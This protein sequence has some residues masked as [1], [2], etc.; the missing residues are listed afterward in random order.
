[1]DAIA[2]IAESR[3][4]EAQEK[5]AFDNLPGMGKPLDLS[6]EANVPQE[7]KMAYTLLKNAGYI[8]GAAHH[9]A[10][11]KKSLPQ[12]EAKA[13]GLLLQHELAATLK[14]KS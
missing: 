11:I 2:F 14:G 5:G 7:L 13:Y 6:D 9:P 4:L 10:A 8:E 1:M 12:E 3:I